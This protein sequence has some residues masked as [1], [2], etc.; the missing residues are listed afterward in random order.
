MPTASENGHS[1]NGV[2]PPPGSGAPL[3]AGGTAVGSSSL[4]LA[5]LQRLANEMFRDGPAGAGLAADAPGEE[6]L[7]WSQLVDG[8]RSAPSRAVHPDPTGPPGG[9][10]V[11][12]PTPVDPRAGSPGGTSLP[13]PTP[14][15]PRAHPA[16]TEPASSPDL[17]ALHGNPQSLADL[18]LLEARRVGAAEPTGD[19]YYFVDESLAFARAQG[20]APDETLTTQSATLPSPSASGG[21]AHPAFDVAALRRDFPVLGEQVHGRPLVWL[22]NAATT[23]KPEAVISRL[24]HFYSHENSNI[25]RAA[26]EMAARATDAYEAARDTVA[27]FL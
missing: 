2:V 17:F 23:Q 27:R 4:D 21:S 19:S 24:D 9:T 22:D 14:V 13:A 20:L 5:E 16:P 10:S 6:A 7:Q 3:F 18:G 1:P 8:A 12:G 15:D 26:H 25:H 11:P